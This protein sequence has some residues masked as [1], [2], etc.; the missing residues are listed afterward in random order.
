MDSD[1]SFL[2]HRFATVPNMCLEGEP[3]EHSQATR[4]VAQAMFRIQLSSIVEKI[5]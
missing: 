2:G 4:L 5:I 3:A 1:G